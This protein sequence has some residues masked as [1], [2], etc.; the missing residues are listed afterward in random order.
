MNII[1]SMSVSKQFLN[2]TI[3]KN[4]NFT[5]KKGEI[6]AIV[7]P[8]GQGKTTFLRILVGLEKADGG[9]IKING[10]SLLEDGTYN[11]NKKEVDDIFKDVSIVF[12]EHN[13]FSNLT[14]IDNLK[15][16]KDDTK[17]ISE[18]LEDFGLKGTEQLFPAELSGGQKQRLSIIRSLLLDPKIILF[19]EPTSALDSENRVK[20]AN[21]IKKLKE[22]LYTIIIVTHDE[23]FIDLLD[24]I[25]YHI[26]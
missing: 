7:G 13:L 8:S 23:K 11:K 22:N 15:I 19:D 4:L 5:A 1:E 21:I 12:Q 6:T 24:P 16:V 20:I 3:F 18:L 14:V 25:I 26:K 17:K 9:T 10:K 2:K